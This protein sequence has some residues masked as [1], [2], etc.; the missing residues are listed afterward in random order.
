M[1][2]TKLSAWSAM[3][4]L[5]LLAAVP[6][7]AQAPEGGKARLTAVTYAAEAVAGSVTLPTSPAGALV[8][9]PCAGCA[10]KSFLTTLDTQYFVGKEPVTIAQL[11]AAKLKSP[12]SILTVSYNIKTGVVTQVTAAP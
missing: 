7:H 11:Q 4:A 9:A 1:T 6:A 2:H 8:M 5:T 10:P 12:Q 3:A